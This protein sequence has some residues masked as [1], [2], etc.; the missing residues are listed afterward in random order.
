MSYESIIEYLTAYLTGDIE[1]HTKFHHGD[2]NYYESYLNVYNSLKQR[3]DF[4]MFAGLYCQKFE[5]TSQPTI[6]YIIEVLEHSV[7][8]VSYDEI[9][10]AS[11]KKIKKWLHTRGKLLKYLKSNSSPRG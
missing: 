9:D 10:D 6:P 7:D 4:S 3:R 5:I 2:I 8:N 1:Y 11:P